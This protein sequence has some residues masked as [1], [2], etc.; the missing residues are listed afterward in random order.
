[1]HNIRR[2]A[3]LLLVP[4]VAWVAAC[5]DAG[6]PE[7]EEDAQITLDVAQYAADATVDDIH[8][9]TDGTDG[10]LGGPQ[11]GPPWGWGRG[12]NSNVN[13]TREVTFYDEAEEEMDGYDAD[14]TASIHFYMLLEGSREHTNQRGVSWSF[15]I[16]RE[17]D[18]WLTGLLGQETQ[19]T[20]NGTGTA[21]RNRTHVS[22]RKGERTYDFSSSLTV[23]DVVIPVPRTDESWPLSGTVTRE[24]HVEIVTGFGDTKTR[25]RTV[26]ITFNGT[27]FVPIVINGVEYT[28]DLATGEI[29]EGD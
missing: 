14:L 7:S 8:L 16:H 6:A 15:T 27:Q 24:V 21:T 18:F 3:T 28:L 10:V 2:H 22:D 13:F 29:V 23:E 1:M 17:R 20:W 11:A 5:S 12:W 25:D 26:V 9:M 4:M 19:R